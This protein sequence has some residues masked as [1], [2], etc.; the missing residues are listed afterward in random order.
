MSALVCLCS[1]GN[2]NGD[3]DDVLRLL[4]VNDLTTNV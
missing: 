1:E 3:D 4:I 2:A